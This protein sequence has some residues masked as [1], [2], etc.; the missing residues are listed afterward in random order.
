MGKECSFDVFVGVPQIGML[1]ETRS[2]LATFALLVIRFP[3]GVFV[4]SRT[5]QQE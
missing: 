5:L 1:E 4:F 3:G 2:A